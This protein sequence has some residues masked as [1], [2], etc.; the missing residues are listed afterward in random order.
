VCEQYDTRRKQFKK[1][2]LRWRGKRSPGWV[3][4]KASGIK[5]IDDT[6]RYA[7]QTF[8]FWKSRELPGPV[9]C[10]NFAQEARGRW[11]VSFVVDVPDEAPTTGTKQVG[12]DPGLKTLATC[13]DGRKIE[14]PRGYRRQQNRIAEAQRKRR[15]RQARNLQAKIAN[16]RKDFLHKESDRLTKE[17]ELIVVGDVC[18]SNLAK[19][20]L[21]KSVN[22]TGWAM[23]K[24]LLSYK[25]MA[26][27]VV[28]REVSERFSTQTCSCCG[29]IGGPKGREGL[30]VR[31]WVCGECGTR[32]D[33]N[34]NA[35]LNILRLGHQS[36]ALK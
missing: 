3:P 27:K 36:L 22:D 34:T 29:S 26:R 17:C 18:S 10:G 32:H 11:Y 21:A 9:K 31:E 16:R 13:S 5:V 33:R 6:V 14:A 8:R 4:F 25:A 2:R 19:T 1:R 35:A 24:N 7:G 15:S 28:Y 30:G 12:I 23:F 20:N